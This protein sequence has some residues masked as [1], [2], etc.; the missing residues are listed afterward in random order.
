MN[1]VRD[2]F[3][4]GFR[5]ELVAAPF[6]VFAQLIMIFDDAVVDDRQTVERHVRVCIPFTRNTVSGPTCVCD[7][8]VA[9]R[10]V[11][12]ERVLQ[13]LDLADSAHAL[14]VLRT[15]EHRDTSGIVAAIFEPPQPLHEN[16]HDVPLSD[17]TDDSAHGS[18]CPGFLEFWGASVPQTMPTC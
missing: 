18:G 16:G 13:H 15:I 4:V 17:G 8:E 5:S 10:R 7:T 6:Q 11:L 14:E 2:D 1:T 3:G 12:L 9:V